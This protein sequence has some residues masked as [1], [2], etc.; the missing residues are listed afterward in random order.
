MA[1]LTKKQSERKERILPGGIPKYIRCYDNGGKTADRYTIVFTGNYKGRNGCDYYGCSGDPF[2]PLGIGLHDWS[3]DII[4]KPTYSHLGKK[5]KFEIL[6][7]NVKEAVI[8]S[9]SSTWEI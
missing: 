1:T 3:Q 6:P 2:H 4:D 8:Q 9:Y 5:V 7:E